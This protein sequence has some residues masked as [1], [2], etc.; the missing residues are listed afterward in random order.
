MEASVYYTTGRRHVP[1]YLELGAPSERDVGGLRRTCHDLMHQGALA[2]R[3]PGA[4]SF[5]AKSGIMH[6]LVRLTSSSYNKTNLVHSVAIEVVH[7]YSQVLTCISLGECIALFEDLSVFM[8]LL[9]SI[10]ASLVTDIRAY[11]SGR[12]TLVT[13]CFM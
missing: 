4:S 6:G 11:R 2:K 3:T 12:L 1:P 9:R 10:S 13:C 7:I 8:W 5:P